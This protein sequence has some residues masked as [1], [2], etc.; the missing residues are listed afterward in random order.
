MPLTV[1]YFDKS[2]GFFRN[3]LI[4]IPLLNLLSFLFLWSL[5]L[6]GILPIHRIVHSTTLPLLASYISLKEK[7]YYW[8][9]ISIITIFF[10]FKKSLVLG[11]GVGVIINSIYLLFKFKALQRLRSLKFRYVPYAFFFITV[12]SL[13]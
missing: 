2:N 7:K 11:F 13:N 8:L 10:S 5:D 3:F 4:K 9:V 12:N 6:F 1:L